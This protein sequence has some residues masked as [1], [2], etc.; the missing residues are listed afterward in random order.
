MVSA[1]HVDAQRVVIDVGTDADATPQADSRVFAHMPI[2]NLP[3]LTHVA[4]RI[5]HFLT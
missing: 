2:A 4:L 3:I 5:G 1:N